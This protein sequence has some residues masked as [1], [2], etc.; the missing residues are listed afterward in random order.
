MATLTRDIRD[1]G[2]V[3]NVL[4]RLARIPGGGS[5]TNTRPAR[6]KFTGSCKAFTALPAISNRIHKKRKTEST[7]HSLMRCRFTKSSQFR[8]CEYFELTA[9]ITGCHTVSGELFQGCGK[10]TCVCHLGAHRW[11]RKLYND[12]HLNIIIQSGTKC[13]L[14]SDIQS[15]R[16]SR[17]MTKIS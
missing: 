2:R 8:F 1:G 5:K 17:Q 7:H 12:A 11:L 16:Y 3:L 4:S 13:H 15:S 6:S 9:W 14:I 10:D